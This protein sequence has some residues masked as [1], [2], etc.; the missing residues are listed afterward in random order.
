MDSRHTDQRHP[1]RLAA[2]SASPLLLI[3]HLDAVRP[4]THGRERFFTDRVP[5]FLTGA[6]KSPEDLDK[7]DWRRTLPRFQ[8]EAFKDVC[9]LVI[10]NEDEV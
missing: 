3:A 2:N 1:L 9:H 8:G 5:G 6:Y 4:P 7:E 10:Y